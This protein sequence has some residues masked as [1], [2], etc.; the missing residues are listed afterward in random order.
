MIRE[1]SV[2]YEINHFFVLCGLICF[3]E[4]DRSEEYDAVNIMQCAEP[5]TTTEEDS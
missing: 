1:P 4:M 2:V 5:Y 3:L